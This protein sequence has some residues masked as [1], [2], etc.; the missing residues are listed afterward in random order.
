MPDAPTPDDP[1][2]GV[3]LTERQVRII[4]PGHPYV[5]GETDPNTLPVARFE[6]KRPSPDHTGGGYPRHRSVE[7]CPHTARQ[8]SQDVFVPVHR[9][10]AVAWCYGLEW[11]VGEILADMDGKD[12]HHEL[13]MP[14]ANI[15][16]ELEVIGHGDHSSV[17]QAER[18]AWAEDEKRARDGQ[19][20]LDDAERCATP[21]CDCEVAARVGGEQY[22]LEHATENADGE[23]IEVL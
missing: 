22:C 5:V 12:V 10:T 20:R 11:S 14:S 16:G 2:A 19:A 13:G 6:F 7:W 15:E 23:T 8:S 3:R 1:L 18:R 9:L 17:T 4:T 21:R